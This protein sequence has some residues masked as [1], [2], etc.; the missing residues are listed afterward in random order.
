MFSGMTSFPI[1][2]AI[3]LLFWFAV[4]GVLALLGGGVAAVWWAIDHV[5]FT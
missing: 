2:G 5:R 1:S 3:K 4:I